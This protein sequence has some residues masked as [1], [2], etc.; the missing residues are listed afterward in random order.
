VN[1]YDVTDAYSPL[2]G[3]VVEILP[4]GPYAT[5][6]D[7]FRAACRLAGWEGLNTRKEP[8]DA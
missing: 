7:A 8:A 1:G 5:I 3:Q 4:S 2:L 6:T